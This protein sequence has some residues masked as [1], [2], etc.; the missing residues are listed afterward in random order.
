[1]PPLFLNTKRSISNK[2]HYSTKLY[3]SLQNEYENAKNEFDKRK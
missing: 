2:R 3:K 1:M